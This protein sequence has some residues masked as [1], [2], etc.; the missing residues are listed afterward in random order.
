VSW[1]FGIVMMIMMIMM[2]MMMMM[3]MMV[4]F[5]DFEPSIDLPPRSDTAARPKG[6]A[7]PSTMAILPLRVLC[8]INN[9]DDDDDH[10][11]D[12]DDDNND[13]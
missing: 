7:L 10:D 2:M 1:W 5:F 12:D 3:M 11:D 9:N 13:Q 8:T 6:R 4:P